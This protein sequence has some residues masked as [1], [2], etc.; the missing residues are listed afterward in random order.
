MFSHSRGCAK[1]QQVRNPRPGTVDLQLR[2]NIIPVSLVIDGSS[3][4][5]ATMQAIWS[6]YILQVNPVPPIVA[7][8]LMKRIRRAALFKIANVK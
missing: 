7:R 8:I 5:I 1:V 3:N 6:L 4:L 2:L